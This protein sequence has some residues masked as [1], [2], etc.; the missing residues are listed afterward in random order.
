MKSKFLLLLSIL[1]VVCWAV[2]VVPSGAQATALLTLNDGVNPIVSIADQGAG[3]S[4]P[5]VGAVTWIGSLGVWNVNVATGFSE[6]PIPHMD[7]NSFENSTAAGNL[8]ITFTDTG[9]I[10]GNFA[11]MAIGGTL[12]NLYG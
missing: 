2:V 10:A 7:L 1:A 8:T 12:D 4:N 11:N 9:Y 6:S 3:D 5:F